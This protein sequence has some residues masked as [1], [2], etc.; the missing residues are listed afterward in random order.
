MFL[1]EIATRLV[2]VRSLTIGQSIYAASVAATVLL[3]Q[4]LGVRFIC[5]EV[6][7]TFRSA[8]V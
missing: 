8:N 3:K 7:K 1:Q 6:F 5:L 2:S 4:L